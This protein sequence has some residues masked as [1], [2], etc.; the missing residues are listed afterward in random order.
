MAFSSDMTWSR[1]CREVASG[2]PSRLTATMCPSSSLGRDGQ[3]LQLGRPGLA[4]RAA[5]PL[6]GGRVDRQ[7]ALAVV[8]P[9]L[10]GAAGDDLAPAVD[11]GLAGPSASA[12]RRDR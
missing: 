7:H 12:G 6:G 4:E 3:V 11:E 10:A 9:E 5:D 8:E 1:I 2:L